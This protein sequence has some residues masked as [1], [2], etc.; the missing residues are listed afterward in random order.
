MIHSIE[1]VLTKLLFVFAV[2]FCSVTGDHALTAFSI[3]KSLGI[4]DAEHTTT[5]SG[6]DIDNMTEEQLDKV[7][8][9]CNVYSR[10]SPENKLRIVHSL[11]RLKQVCSM[12]GDGVNDAPA[13]R[14]ADCGVAMG[15]AG[16]SVSKEAA[17]IVLTDDRFDTIAV[18][19]REGA[20]SSSRAVC[21]HVCALCTH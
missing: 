8:L 15:I 4:A 16:T 10:V 9:G 20:C 7:V 1:N 21:I 6:A 19:V 5:T 12:T 3:A 13:L 17:K 2:A 11:H 18:A 14:A